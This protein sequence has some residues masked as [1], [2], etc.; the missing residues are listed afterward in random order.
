MVI[1]QVRIRSGLLF[2][3]LP[4]AVTLSVMRPCLAEKAG[5]REVA[6]EIRE[7]RAV[8][9]LEEEG[10][11]SRDGIFVDTRLSDLDS[12][13]HAFPF[14]A[15]QFLGEREV[16]VSMKRKREIHLVTGQ[17]LKLR[18]LSADPEG[19]VLWLRWQAKKSRELLLDTRVRL[20]YGDNVIA[21]AEGAESTGLILAITAAN[22]EVVGG[23]PGDIPASQ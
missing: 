20:N 4:I 14:Q 23:S 17:I 8:A 6:I 11:K 19:I 18:L 21:G 9:M 2:L 12:E 16:R 15:Y 7:I 22:P 1:N 5:S 13:F 10:L 3:T